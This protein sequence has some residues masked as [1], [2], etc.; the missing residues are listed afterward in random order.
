MRCVTK[1]FNQ[2]CLPFST[3]SYVGQPVRL[4]IC[5]FIL[6]TSI[7]IYGTLAHMWPPLDQRLEVYSST[8]TPQAHACTMLMIYSNWKCSNHSSLTLRVLLWVNMFYGTLQYLGY[9]TLQHLL[10]DH[11]HVPCAESSC[12]IAG[13]SS[14]SPDTW[15]CLV[16]Y[17]P[18]L[19]QIVIQWQLLHLM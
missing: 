1:N 10:N 8:D 4:E 11:S 9:K 5:I 19:C 6:Y 18:L 15:H 16:E 13:E 12:C 7:M 3:K 2:R 17:C 14:L